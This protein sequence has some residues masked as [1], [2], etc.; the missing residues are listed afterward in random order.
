M[1]R[2]HPD[3][4]NNNPQ[5]SQWLIPVPDEISCFEH[6]D[7]AGWLKEEVGWG[8]HLPD[9]QPEWLGVATDR[10]TQLFYAKFVTS[11]GQPWHGYPADQRRVNDIP[12]ESVLSEWMHQELFTRA[13]IRKIVQGRPCSL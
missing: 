2:P 1:Y 9:G 3:H 5:K 11:A 13:K 10:Q 6:A 8:L 4:R 12:H 7:G